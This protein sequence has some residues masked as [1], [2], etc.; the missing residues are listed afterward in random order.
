MFV[1]PTVP[2]RGTAWGSGQSQ[3]A[4]HWRRRAGERATVGLCRQAHRGRMFACLLLP[5]PGGRDGQNSQRVLGGPGSAHVTHSEAWGTPFYTWSGRGL[6]APSRWQGLTLS[7]AE[8]K[9]VCVCV[10]V[11]VCD[12]VI[13]G[14]TAN[15][16]LDWGKIWA[17]PPFSEKGGFALL[18]RGVSVCVWFR[19]ACL[20]SQR[21][22]CTAR[23]NPSKNVCVCAMV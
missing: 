3:V 9:S 18:T 11:C 4:R 16:L 2:K 23:S 13:F 21:R 8:T 5:G 14:D 1:P 20:L 17:V 10:R 15:A 19:L 7:S 6:Q 22:D 12:G